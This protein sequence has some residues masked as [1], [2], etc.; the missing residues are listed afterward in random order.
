VSVTR[1]L[2]RAVGP[3]KI[4][5]IS[6]TRAGRYGRIVEFFSSRKLELRISQTKGE[7]SSVPFYVSATV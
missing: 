7:L 1:E 6:P 2:S 3:E 5:R 4:P